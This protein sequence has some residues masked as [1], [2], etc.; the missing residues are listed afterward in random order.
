MSPGLIK[1]KFSESL[2]SQGE[3]QAAE[4]NGVK[5]LGVPEDIGSVVKFLLSTE[6][7]YITGENLVVAGR[8]ISRL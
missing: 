1:T 8:P 6:A 5:R 3:K 7:G 2:W 4:S